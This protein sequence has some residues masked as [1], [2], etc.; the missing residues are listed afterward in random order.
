MYVFNHAMVS[1]PSGNHSSL[2]R[3]NRP[4]GN[5]KKE[6]FYMTVKEAVLAAATEL[7]IFEEVENYILGV[8]E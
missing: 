5:Y 2:I 1:L 8:S 4:L 6:D 7:G 3:L